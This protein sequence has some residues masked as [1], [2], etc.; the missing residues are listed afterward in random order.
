[1]VSFHLH[2]AHSYCDPA[3]S[4]RE[5][6]RHRDSQLEEVDLEFEPRGHKPSPAPHLQ[7]LVPWPAIVAGGFQANSSE[8]PQGGQ[9]LWV[10]LLK[11]MLTDGYCGERLGKEEWQIWAKGAA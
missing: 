1:M 3:F 5:K 10:L 7:P 9:G 4:Q 6:L 11:L 2:G 8:S